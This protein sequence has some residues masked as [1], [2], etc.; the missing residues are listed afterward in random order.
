[1]MKFIEIV[2][3]YLTNKYIEFKGEFPDEIK[4]YEKELDGNRKRII[5][6]EQKEMTE[7]QRLLLMK[8]IEEK[9]K[10]IKL[11]PTRNIEIMRNKPMLKKGEKKPILIKHREPMLEDFILYETQEFN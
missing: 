11:K 9:F 1:M 7:N 10:K 2:Y 8:K 4:V 5:A 3:D 6:E